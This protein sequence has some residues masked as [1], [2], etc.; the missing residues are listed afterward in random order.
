MNKCQNRQECEIPS[1]IDQ[2]AAIP[3]VI[4]AEV[5]GCSGIPWWG[6]T[7]VVKSTRDTKAKPIMDI[8]RQNGR[9]AVVMWSDKTKY[10]R[11][12]KIL[13]GAIKK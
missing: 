4:H 13:F 12:R 3:G 6:G 7:I 5:Y 10:G 11:R 9:W 8:I 2:I 1:K